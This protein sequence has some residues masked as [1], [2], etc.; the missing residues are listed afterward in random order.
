MP[1]WNKEGVCGLFFHDDPARQ[2]SAS[3]GLW[4]ARD[5]TQSKQIVIAATTIEVMSYSACDGL[6][7]SQSLFLSPNADMLSQKQEALLQRTVQT[8]KN[9]T[10]N[11]LEKV[12]IAMRNDE[13]GIKLADQ[14]EKC[15]RSDIPVERD[16]PEDYATWNHFWIDLLVRK[17][18]SF[19]AWVENSFCEAELESIVRSEGQD[20]E[21]LHAQNYMDVLYSRFGGDIWNL[22]MDSMQQSDAEDMYEYFAT[23]S[24]ACHVYD[25]KSHNRFLIQCA[26]F[27]TARDILAREPNNTPVPEENRA[28]PA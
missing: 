20:A 24:H 6:I 17:N 3:D 26:A 21:I 25:E 7:Y 10:V 13:A 11:P 1:H 9:R 23:Y 28:V 19:E 2:L 4:L 22:L 5:H 27:H 15:V 16:L 18:K 14:I 8:M 12:V